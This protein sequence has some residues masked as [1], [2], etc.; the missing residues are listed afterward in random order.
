MN[1]PRATAQHSFKSSKIA[2]SLGIIVVSIIYALWQYAGGQ[3]SVTTITTPLLPQQPTSIQIT[4][5]VSPSQSNTPS[6]APVQ[7]QAPQKPAGLYADGSY[8]GGSADAY[9]GTVQ[10][11]AVIRNE[12]LADVQILQY[13]NSHSTSVFI[14]EQAMPMLVQEAIQ[15]QSAS[16]DGISGATLTSQAFQES[17][18]AALAQA[19]A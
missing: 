11:K 6:P 14:N 4:P 3:R 1:T 13:P 15:A 12:K 17:L 5:A 2:L 16:I 19:K 10:V 9:Y 18:A 8:T 7:V